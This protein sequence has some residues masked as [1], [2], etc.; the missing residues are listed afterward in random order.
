[1]SIKKITIN[2]IQDI[3]TPHNNVLIKY[4]NVS[5]EVE[6]KLWYACEKGV[7]QYDWSSDITHEICD[8][9]IY[10]NKLNWSFIKYCL[11]HPNERFVVV[12][13]MN[14]NTRFLHFLFFLLMRP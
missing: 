14:N 10:G 1:M 6:I 4:L 3:A 9:T 12:G 5:E 8:A 2:L 13:W 7:G 11:T